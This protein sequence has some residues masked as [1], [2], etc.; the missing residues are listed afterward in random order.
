M[1]ALNDLVVVGCG[2]GG[3]GGSGGGLKGLKRE[4]FSLLITHVRRP[5]DMKESWLNITES[6]GQ[7]TGKTPEE[8]TVSQRIWFICWLSSHAQ[9]IAGSASGPRNAFLETIQKLPFHNHIDNTL[10]EEK[11][12]Q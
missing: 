5:H 4:G 1:I 12:K 2:G 8:E 11:T 10:K 6:M 9:R 3:G 7:R